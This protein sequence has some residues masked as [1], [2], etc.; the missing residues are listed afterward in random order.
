[1]TER[2]AFAAALLAASS[3]I[4]AADR[5]VL[6][7][8]WSPDGRACL[9]ALQPLD[10]VE[11]GRG[12][13]LSYGPVAGVRAR[14]AV[15]VAGAGL[16]LAYEHRRLVAGVSLSLVAERSGPVAPVLGAALGFRL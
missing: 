6:S 5:P 15:P 12:L 7:V 10:T 9:L 2:L 16:S 1:M 13:S 4:F 11:V 14:G 8:Q 3:T